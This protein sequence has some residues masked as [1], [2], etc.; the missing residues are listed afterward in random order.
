L[1]STPLG[2]PVRLDGN[3]RAGA[4]QTD[5]HFAHRQARVAAEQHEDLVLHAGYAD[6]A[7]E[8]VAAG[9]QAM[10]VG[11]EVVDQLAEPGVG[12]FHQQRR[13]RHGERSI[14]VSGAGH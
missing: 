9:V 12:A 5:R 11:D 14:P 7:G 3:E 13:A 4:V 2:E 1:A 8:R 10:A 6:D